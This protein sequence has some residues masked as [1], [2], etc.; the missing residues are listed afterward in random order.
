MDEFWGTAW[1][2]GPQLP[3][4]TDAEIEAWQKRFGVRLPP[5]LAAALQVQ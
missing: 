4:A 3:V 5:T 2:L 1:P